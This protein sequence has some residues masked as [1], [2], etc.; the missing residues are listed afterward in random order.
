MSNDELPA[1]HVRIGGRPDLLV[2]VEETDELFR[3]DPNFDIYVRE[4]LV[5][6]DA[7]IVRGLLHALKTL[8]GE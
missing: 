4:V 7:E 3:I 2:I 1:G 8:N 6:D 5:T